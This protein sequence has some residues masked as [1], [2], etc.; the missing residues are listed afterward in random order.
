MY[1]FFSILQLCGFFL[2]RFFFFINTLTTWQIILNTQK[3]AVAGKY[4][5]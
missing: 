4:V 2:F 1:Q 3:V 5:K